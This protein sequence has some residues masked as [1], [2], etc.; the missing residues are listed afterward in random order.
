M[1]K[2][3]KSWD[4]HPIGRVYVGHEVSN[5][6]I[7]IGGSYYQDSAQIHLTVKEAKWLQ[8]HLE[9]ALKRVRKDGK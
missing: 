8:R 9:K 4:S 1:K 6:L 3:D 7:Y 5:D 2:Q